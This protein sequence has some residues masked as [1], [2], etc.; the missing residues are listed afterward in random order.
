MA[1]TVVCPGC[2]FV[3]HV[4]NATPGDRLQCPRCQTIIVINPQP[5]QQLNSTTAPSVP[6]PARDAVASGLDEFFASLGQRRGAWEPPAI[7]WA[8]SAPPSGAPE[9]VPTTEPPE[10]PR[11]ER[12]WLKD[13]RQRLYSYVHEQ[14]ERLKQRQ[15][16][17]AA[18][19]TEV[20]AKLFTNEQE[21]YRQRMHQKA[22]EEALAE[23]ETACARTEEELSRKRAQHDE[24]ITTQNQ[25]R[26]EA[27]AQAER[28]RQ[29]TKAAQ[30]EYEALVKTLAAQKAAG[31]E[32]E[33]RLAARAREL[34]KRQQEMDQAEQA[35]QRRSA[36]L[37]EVEAQITHNAGQLESLQRK[38]TEAERALEHRSA[39]LEA[40]LSAREQEL[41]RQRIHL[42]AHEAALGE[43]EIACRRAADDLSQ[44]HQQHEQSLAVEKTACAEEQSRLA[45]RAAELEKRHQEADRA[46]Q[47][48]QRRSAELEEVETRLKRDA[49]HHEERQ[50]N[51]AEAEQS[52]QRRLAEFEASLSKREQELEGQRRDSEARETLLEK[53]GCE[54]ELAQQACQRRSADLEEMEARLTRDAGELERHRQKLAETEEAIERRIAELEEWSRIADERFDDLDRLHRALEEA[55][56]ELQRRA[57]MLDEAGARILGMLQ[58]SNTLSGAEGQGELLEPAPSPP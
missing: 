42:Q 51:L 47:A 19:N 15:Q 1:S 27:A 45:A 11:L 32:E 8:A 38:V 12:E 37:E 41:E 13:E 53:S 56:Q 24:A 30:E 18:F 4:D 25:A 57:A 52:V 7:D 20:Q 44:Q 26:G 5:N 6:V 49:G 48:W 46:E 17:F 10:D 29:K 40:Q 23:R 9:G 50:Q 3:G 54:L 21:L 39:E 22:R 31:G 34:E 58:T 16:E 2:G 35:W 33:A 28:W 55:D 43:R 14:F 36:E